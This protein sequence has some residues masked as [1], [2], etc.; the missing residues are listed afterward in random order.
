[1]TSRLCATCDIYP[2]ASLLWPF[3]ANKKYL[4]TIAACMLRWWVP[5]LLTRLRKASLQSM[6]PEWN[7]VRHWRLCAY[8]VVLYVK[9]KFYRGNV[10]LSRLCR[11][12][13]PQ[14][15][16]GDHLWVRQYTLSERKCYTQEAPSRQKSRDVLTSELDAER[17]VTCVTLQIALCIGTR[18]T[19][20]TA[21]PARL[22]SSLA[23][24]CLPQRQQKHALGRDIGAEGAL[25][26]RLPHTWKTFAVCIEREIDRI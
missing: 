5:Y 15:T 21:A 24:T 18:M 23:A 2:E 26:P 8:K 17:V 3:G 19:A 12:E 4:D 25:L 16:R 1:M 6:W 20:P 22:G 14:T 11:R 10:D 7:L 13:H 9:F